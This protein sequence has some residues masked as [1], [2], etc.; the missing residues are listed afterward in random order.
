[1]VVARG[2]EHGLLVE[3]ESESLKTSVE[4]PRS[5]PKNCP[6][7]CAS[8]LSHQQRVCRRVQ[9]AQRLRSC[10]SGAGGRFAAYKAE[11]GGSSP[12]APTTTDNI[13]RGCDARADG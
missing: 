8:H 2:L 6:R 11:D 5:R 13:L 12:S 10:A 4:G 3:R 1:M 7:N 9:A